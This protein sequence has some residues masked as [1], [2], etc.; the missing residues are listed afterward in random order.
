M[1]ADNAAGLAASERL[2]LETLDYLVRLPVNPLTA[3]LALKIRAHLADPAQASEFKNAALATKAAERNR[4]L[5]SGVAWYTPA[6]LPALEVV[7]HTGCSAA[8]VSSPAA[9]TYGGASA[10][11]QFSKKLIDALI[12]GQE[13][14]LGPHASRLTLPVGR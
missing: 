11:K 10:G 8:T 6:G 4:D 5:R 3:Q 12:I 7:V 14:A 1:T 13:V 9:R 2:L